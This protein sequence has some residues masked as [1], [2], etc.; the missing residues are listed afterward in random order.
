M[1]TDKERLAIL[2][3]N[4]M[5]IKHTVDRIDQRVEDLN[6]F[7]FKIMGAASALAT[8]IS[9]VVATLAR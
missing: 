1:P 8:L 4:I 2:E 7:R 5:Y 9:F 6:A 3:T